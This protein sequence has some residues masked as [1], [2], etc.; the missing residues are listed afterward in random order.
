MEKQIY[1]E[2]IWKIHVAYKE[3]IASPPQGYRFVGAEG[4]VDKVSLAVSR[5]QLAPWL[6]AQAYSLAPMTLLKAYLDR[7]IRRPPEGTA[8]TFACNHLVFRR[9]PWVIEL[10]S[11]SDPIGF[12]PHH[13]WRY[14]S[15]LER[16]FAS[17]WCKKVLCWS[18]FTK[19]TVLASLDCS[20][21]R[22][23]LEVVPRAVRPR[24]FTRPPRDRESV[25]F[26]FLGSANMAGEFAARG[27]LEVVEAF[28]ALRQ[29]SESLELT[30]R[31]DLPPDVRRRLRGC[32]DV[33]VIEGV[34]PSEELERL[35]LT[36]DI[37]LFPGYYSAW[38]VILEAMSYGLPVIATDVH[39]TSEYVNDGRTGLLLRAGRLP[40]G[41]G[42]L[43]VT[44]FIDTQRKGLRTPDH[45]VVA[46]L[47]E[48]AGLLI[49][50]E[51][52]RQRMGRQ[53]RYEVQ[54]GRFSIE[55][56]NS[57]LKRILDEAT[58]EAPEG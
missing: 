10:G 7:F 41:H 50:N 21:F 29:R 4:V 26:L 3:L 25:R 32:P 52:L 6:M 43:P 58:Q 2:P 11:V 55:R 16:A 1:L 51:E 34:I 9:E 49:E 35:F 54:R 47:V 17:G 18:E 36:H 5:R 56:R 12:S 23:K 27:G 46:D 48:K 14:K 13:F 22:P 33:R 30:I 45:Q 24:S 31:S 8:L 38:L 40:D 19:R 57:V 20:Q 15:V 39:S 53:A 42:E 44:G 28:L 37:F